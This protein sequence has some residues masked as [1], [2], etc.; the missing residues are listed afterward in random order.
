MVEPNKIRLMLVKQGI[1]GPSP[2]FLLGNISE[3]RRIQIDEASR[4]ANDTKSEKI[5]H[6]W[7][8]SVFAYLHQYINQ[9][10]NVSFF[11]LNTN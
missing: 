1:R 5:S 10:G 9:Y 2:S 11:F 4:A 3:I 6:S 7:S 8:P